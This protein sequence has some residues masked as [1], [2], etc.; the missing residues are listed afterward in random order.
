VLNRRAGNT[1][2]VSVAE[3]AH[4]VASTS[5]R[6]SDSKW[7]DRA[8]R[9]GFVARAVVY[10]IVALL[11]LRLA[12]GHQNGEQANKQDALSYGQVL[13]ALTAVA[14]LAFAAFSGFEARYRRL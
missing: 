4:D 3:K 6:A 10:A 1:S 2:V 11:A 9:L 12:F 5:Q 7:L 13:R 14:L 8:A